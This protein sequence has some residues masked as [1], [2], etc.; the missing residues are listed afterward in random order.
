LDDTI[1]IKLRDEKVFE[2]LFREYF[3]ILYEYALF[4][5]NNSEQAEDIV[6]DIFLKIW[7]SRDNLIITVSIKAYLFR[8]VHNNCIQF[9]KHKSVK[10][11]TD[12]YL[13]AKFEESI[14]MGQL[15]FESGLT[16][17]F[18]EEIE[19]ITN[20]SINFLPEKTRKIY[21]LSRI[22][23]LKN[24]KIAEI[25]Q[26]TEKAV[27]YHITK[28]LGIIRNQLHDYIPS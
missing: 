6:Q 19:N 28:A 24:S 15:F 9:L 12:V 27:E 7:E 4:Y 11:K 14:L 21:I 8:C 26:I 13:Q 18:K 16:R 20:Q 17:L 1:N 22:G 3:M 2:R 10:N 23:H 25:F 5:T